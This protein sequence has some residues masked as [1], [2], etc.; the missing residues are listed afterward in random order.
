MT[1]FLMLTIVTVLSWAAT[2]PAHDKPSQSEPGGYDN[3][4]PPDSGDGSAPSGDAGVAE[5]N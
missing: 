1:G 5:G 4:N 3:P 2:Y